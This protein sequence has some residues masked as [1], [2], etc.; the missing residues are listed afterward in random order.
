MNFIHGKNLLLTLLVVAL[1][2]TTLTSAVVA[3]STEVDDAEAQKHLLKHVDAIYPPIAK[4]AHV[5][6]DVILS[7]EIGKDGHV[8]NV[9]S[10]GGPSMLIGAATDAVNKWEYQP[11]EKSGSLICVSTKVR[12]PF[13]LGIPVDSKDEEIANAYFPL[14]RKCIQ[15]V[16]Q[17]S[18]PAEQATACQ[19]AAEQADRFSTDSRFIERRSAYVYYTTSLIRDKRPKEAVVSGE[20]AIAVVLQGHDDGSGSSAAYGVTGQAKALSGDLAGGDKDL[21]IA[22]DFQRKALDSPA[23]HEL[24]KSYSQTLKSLLTFHAQVLNALGK[25][26][27]A[28]TKLSE[29]SKL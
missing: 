9:K 21:E 12:V 23:G 25:Q 26:A 10:L 8:L 14:S 1:A 24:N 4:A 29:A 2:F 7:I 20:K 11:F 22:E 19:K 6:G 15:L 3:Q 5:Q 17:G 13:A 28:Q 27:Q 18:D 16:S